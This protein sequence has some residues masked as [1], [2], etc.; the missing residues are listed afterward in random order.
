MNGLLALLQDHE[1]ISFEDGRYSN[2]ICKVIMKLLLPRISMNKMNDVIKLK[3][4]IHKLPSAGTKIQFMP[5]T[6]TLS[7]VQVSEAL[8]KDID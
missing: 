1:I 8:V 5:K 4:D 2:D 6:L 7:Q 3:N